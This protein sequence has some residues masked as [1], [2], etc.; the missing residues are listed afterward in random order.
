MTRKVAWIPWL[1]AVLLLVPAVPAAASGIVGAQVEGNAVEAK[2]RLPGG[3]GADLT[4]AFEQVVGLSPASLGLSVQL[5]DAADLLALASRL[6]SSLV[7]VPSGFPVLLTIE[8]PQTGGLS[9]SG[10]ATVELYT[11]ALTF[12]PGCP[13][14]LYAAPLGGAFHDI[15]ESN[16]GGS[17][18]VRGTKG[19][20]S[21][22]LI[23]ADLRTVEQAIDVKFS[24][25]G[26]KLTSHAAAITPAVY[27][28]LVA[29]L[30]AAEAAYGSGD[31]LG[32]IAAVETFADTVE[33]HSGAD[34]PDVWRS[35]RDLDNAAGDL[36]AAAATLR[37]SLLLKANA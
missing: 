18:R 22:F 30:D 12:V 11:H 25:L 33:S 15:T 20:F 2:I 7:S 37:F 16:A 26:Q 4:V 28:D 35:A 14:R 5:L 8:P 19:E 27:S 34:I 23:V 24:R 21:E 13:F 3:V 31:T 32:A 29:L 36:R 10:V 9:F 6:P 1:L 17:Y